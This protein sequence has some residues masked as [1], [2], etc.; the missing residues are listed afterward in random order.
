MQRKIQQAQTFLF[1]TDRPTDSSAGHTETDL[2]EPLTR[3]ADRDGR[4]VMRRGTQEVVYS[5]VVA[6]SW[7]AQYVS[8]LMTEGIAEG[9]KDADG[10]LTGEYGVA[11]PV[12]KAEVLKMALEV[13]NTRLV[14]SNPRNASAGNTWA[15]AYVAT[16]ES[17]LLSVFHP[18]TDVHQ[19][20]TR[21]EVLQIIVEIVKAPRSTTPPPFTDVPAD[22][23]Y[24]PA[25]AAAFG[26]GLI[27]GDKGGDGTLLH[28][29]RPD[30]FI[31][32]AEVS[33][34]IAMMLNGG[35]N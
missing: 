32:R 17:L 34:I 22:H 2:Q 12:T 8:I 28:R 23:P 27:E 30:A 9:Y 25:I 14:R 18:S 35:K 3:V 15:S 20:A 13:T 21:G 16:A 5:D 31:N 10:N 24:A 7:Y 6:A 11:N 1:G 26:L 4:L 29:F 33:K 19:H